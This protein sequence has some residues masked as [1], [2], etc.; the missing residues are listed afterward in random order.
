MTSLPSIEVLEANH[1]FP[2][3]YL[4]KAIG[5]NENNFVQRTVAAV[6]QELETDADPPY[7]LR[8]TPAK[9]HVS[10]SIEC[11]VRNAAEVLAVYRRLLTVEGLVLLW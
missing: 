1:T 2:G 11:P 9:R 6:R 3:S 4:F 10:V 8:E 7:T 5:T